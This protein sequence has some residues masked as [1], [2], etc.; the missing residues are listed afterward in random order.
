[1]DRALLT[2]PLKVFSHAGSEIF[3]PKARHESERQIYSGSHASSGSH[4]LIDY[5]SV[6]SPDIDFVSGQRIEKFVMRGCGQIFQNA[7]RRE[8]KRTRAY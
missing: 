5:K 7:G 4:M 8:N 1:M 6:A 3:A 2:F